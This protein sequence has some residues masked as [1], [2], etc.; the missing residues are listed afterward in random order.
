M[1]SRCS[2]TIPHTVSEGDAGDCYCFNKE[3][4][5]VEVFISHDLQMK[6]VVNILFGM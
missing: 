1:V 2:T 3:M 6:T 4:D 5:E